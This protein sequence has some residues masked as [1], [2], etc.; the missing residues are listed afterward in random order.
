MKKT[1]ICGLG[2]AGILSAHVLSRFK[3]DAIL[4]DIHADIC[5]ATSG[6]NSACTFWI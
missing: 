2:I 3:N 6:A 1:F 5:E 4:C